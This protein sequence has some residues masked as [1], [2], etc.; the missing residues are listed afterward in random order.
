[1]AVKKYFFDDGKA[2]RLRDEGVPIPEIARMLGVSK[3]LVRDRTVSH[4][5]PAERKVDVGKAQALRNA[6]WSIS[7]IANELGVKEIEVAKR[8]HEPVAKKAFALEGLGG[9]V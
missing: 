5:P 1:M 2:Q 6:G 8:I 7:E 9:Y 4:V 3:S